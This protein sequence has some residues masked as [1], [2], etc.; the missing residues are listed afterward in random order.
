MKQIT[1]GHGHG[2][3]GVGGHALEDLA[4]TNDGG[5]NDGETG[6]GQH[7]VSSTASSISGT[8]SNHV[9][10]EQ[11]CNRIETPETTLICAAMQVCMTKGVL[12]HG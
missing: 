5:H 12:C 9:Y 10:L 11:C 1:E 8:C 6:A 2:V 4:G 3:L 7:N